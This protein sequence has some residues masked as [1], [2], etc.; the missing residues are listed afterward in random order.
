MTTKKK[1]LPVNILRIHSLRPTTTRDKQISRGVGQKMEIITESK[2]ALDKL[3]VWETNIILVHQ[4]LET[5]ARKLGLIEVVN[6]FP[7]LEIWVRKKK[8]KKKK[9]LGKKEEPQQGVQAPFCRDQ[10]DH[11]KLHSH[12]QWRLSIKK[13]KNI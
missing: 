6:C 9:S 2:S 4:H 5:F 7:G 1:D 10:R 12:R 3:S 13:K 8:K 11:T